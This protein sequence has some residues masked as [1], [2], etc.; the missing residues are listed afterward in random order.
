[1]KVTAIVNGVFL[2]LEQ[3]EFKGKIKQRIKLLQNLE[4]AAVGLPEGK[5]NEVTKLH[6]GA[7]CT[8]KVDI[9]SFKDKPG[10]YMRL[11]EV[12]AKGRA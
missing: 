2:G 7:E 10:M 6:S 4:V 1:M 11:V 8:M 3:S 5:V 9:D 12:V